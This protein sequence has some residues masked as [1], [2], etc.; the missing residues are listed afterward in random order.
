MRA[1]LPRHGAPAP[2]KPPEPATRTRGVWARW[3]ALAAVLALVLRAAGA[4]AWPVGYA[5]G[6]MVASV[7]DK[8]ANAAKL[9]IVVLPFEN[10]S[11]DKEQDDFADVTTNLSHLGGSFVI[12]RNTAFTYKG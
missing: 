10:L 8:L 1:Y 9:S 4:F 5:P 12:A 11:G 3:P 7:D 2:Q 6:F